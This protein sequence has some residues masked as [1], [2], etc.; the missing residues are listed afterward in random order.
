[1]IRD[2]TK[3]YV[4]E[5]L[6][7]VLQRIA[8]SAD[9]TEQ[10]CQILWELGRD[11]RREL[12]QFP[13]HAIRVLADLAAYAPRKPVLYSAKVLRTAERWLD[14]PDLPSYQNSPLD[15]V[16]PLLAKQAEYQKLEGHTISFGFVGINLPAVAS[17]RKD[18][19]RYVEECLRH[20]HPRVAGRALQV[21]R[22]IVN[23]PAS[24]GGRIV[25]A[26]EME[27][28][29]PEQLEGVRLLKEFITKTKS[30]VLLV[31][32]KHEFYWHSENGQPTEVA[33][34]V[35]DA[36]ARISPSLDL[37]IVTALTN[38]LYDLGRGKID[39]A[40]AQEKFLTDLAARFLK[41]LP[42]A[43]GLTK[44][45]SVLGDIHQARVPRSGAQLLS[46][47]GR[48]KAEAELI[49][50][51]V[52]G[53]QD[54]PL[55]DYAGAVLGAL[56]LNHAESAIRFA[57]RMVT[58]GN[59]LGRAV[60]ASYANSDSLRHPRDEDFVLLRELL[61]RDEISKRY[62]LEAVRR[63]KDAEPAAQAR[64]FQRSGIDLLVG[65]DIGQNPRMAEVFAE[66]ID[67]NFGIP[68]DLLTD[69]DVEVILKKLVSVREITHQNFHLARFLA[70]LVRRSPTRVVEFFVNRIEY[71]MTHK[72]EQGYTPTPFG[73][74]ELFA[75]IA[76]TPELAAIVRVLAKSLNVQDVLK[77]YW[78]TKL[79]GLVAGSFGPAT[80][81][82][83]SDLAEGKTEENY[84][85]IA[86]LL[87]EAPREFVF[88]EKDFCAKL[89]ESANGISEQA[90]KST[91]GQ[92]LASTQSGGFSGIP[93]Q[94]FPQ[95][96]S[97]K[98]RAAK[99]AAEYAER[100]VVAKFYSDVAKFA[101]EMI[102]KQLERDEED[103]VE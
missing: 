99:L 83:I 46:E 9:Y 43:V 39:F 53:H 76:D 1:M 30:Q 102:D 92:L 97:I 70:F 84:K 2:L 12:N 87:Q 101:Q 42:G 103:F 78:F 93:G 95:Q 63:L 7:P 65:A 44:I 67:S 28:W 15:V 25:T 77:R 96:V 54:C 4:I 36:L 86:V 16:T 79:F 33:K 20:P 52:L 34:G 59:Q 74:E 57:Q 35:S 50:E 10:A 62:A 38:A 17:V 48:D 88:S 61:A 19:I 11:D 81:A 55:I 26:E 37:D 41:E 14:D 8:F 85:L 60:G 3:K 40:T 69:D 32:A 6:P 47:L 71:S 80:Q 66:A 27:A 29:K 73:L 75:Q 51:H 49:L 94:P 18:A 64:I 13:N 100:P 21:V 22:E 90:F 24:L 56:R 82:V 58:S 23:H 91:S 31:L 68:P 45:E 5:A 89:L 72:D 98:D